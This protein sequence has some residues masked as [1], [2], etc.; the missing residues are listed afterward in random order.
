M[1]AGRRAK[2]TESE[3]LQPYKKSSNPPFPMTAATCGHLP[4]V[5]Q[6]GLNL[7]RELLKESQLS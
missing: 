3:R 6:P 2:N 7:P 5:Y 4:G 1:S